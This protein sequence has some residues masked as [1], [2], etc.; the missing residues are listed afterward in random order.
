MCIIFIAVA[1][2][3]GFKYVILSNRDEAYHRDTSTVHFWSPDHPDLLAGTDIN[4]R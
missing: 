1:V 4:A 3:A 2:H